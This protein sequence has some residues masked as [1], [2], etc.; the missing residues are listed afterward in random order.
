MDTTIFS[1]SALQYAEQ[2]D[3]EII[4]Y[5]EAC[6]MNPRFKYLFPRDNA[7]LWQVN[8]RTVNSIKKVIIGDEVIL[9]GKTMDKECTLW[10]EL[11]HGYH[12]TGLNQGHDLTMELSADAWAFINYD[13]GNLQLLIEDM[14]W[15]IRT[16]LELGHEKCLHTLELEA[17]ARTLGIY[18]QIIWIKGDE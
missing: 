11:G 5:G 1:D 13:G 18:D 16:Y 15:A 4:S 10:H 12:P 14:S 7:G 2:A 8:E 6:L 3:I 17:T 9:N